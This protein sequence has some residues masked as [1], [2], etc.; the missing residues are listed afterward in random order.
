[1]SVAFSFNQD[2]GS[3]TMVLKNKP[4]V[5]NDRHRYFTR[6]KQML[7]SG[8]SE[9]K[10]LKMV[11]SVAIRPQDVR[12]VSKGRAEVRN[13]KVYLDGKEVHNAVS[14]RIY[15]FI[16]QDLPF[17]H[18]LRFLENVKKNP[19]HR[20]QEE[21]F[22]FLEH[23]NLPITPD[24]CFY[25]Y[26]AVQPNLMDI[27]SGTIDNSIGN[28]ISMERPDVDDDC[29]RGCSKGLHCGTLEY[30]ESYGGSNCRL[31][32]V[33]VNPADVVSVPKDCSCQK[34]RTCKYI[35]H[36][37]YEKPLV[38]PMYDDNMQS[39][40][41]QYDDIDWDEVDDLDDDYF[42]DGD[43]YVSTNQPVATTYNTN[44]YNKRDSKGRFSK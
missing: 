27:Y 8:E 37:E 30:A 28:V 14:Q 44:Y 2:S 6:I 1:M 40:V 29:T 42:D 21:L 25:A 9:D 13:G 11:E 5:I 12:Q 17:D 7:V 35:C 26:K 15:D 34:V 38:D 22:T 41:T 43:I 32:I 10:I 4:V 19:S 3:L 39:A 18:L 31:I 24:G 33:K 23:Q 36:V 20:A 16:R